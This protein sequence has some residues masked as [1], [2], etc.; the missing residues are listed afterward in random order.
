V[1]PGARALF[2]LPAHACR[3][4]SKPDLDDPRFHWCGE[5]AQL[6]GPCAVH[7][8]R[9][10]N[11]HDQPRGLVDAIPRALGMLGRVGRSPDAVR[12]R[13]VPTTAE[14]RDAHLARAQRFLGEG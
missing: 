12:P 2:E 14:E 6:G 11:H 7:A 1:S 10:R 3:W 5:P 4:P 13:P 9:S 8:E